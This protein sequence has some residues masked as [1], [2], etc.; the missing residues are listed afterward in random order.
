MADL[1][2]YDGVC[3]LCDRAVRFVYERDRTGRF[4]YAS[5]QSGVAREVL[6]RHGK[7][8]SVLETVYVLVDYDSPNERLLS[9]GRAALHILRALGGGWQLAAIFGVLPN[10]VLDAGYD[11][12]ASR[13]YSIFGR[14]DV[15]I[16][17]APEHRGRF[18]DVGES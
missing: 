6:R 12:V 15:C 7:D 10:R 8:S 16:L 5:L 9:K 14:S 1:L 11:F 3:G 13:R 2:L 4:L 18:L 17:P